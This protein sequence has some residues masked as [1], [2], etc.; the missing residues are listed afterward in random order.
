MKYREL[1]YSRTFNLGQYES[2]RIGLRVDL[3]EIED[4][5]ETF[6]T[7]KGRVFKLHEEGRLLEDS[8][9]A[10]EADKQSKK[11][12]SLE[13]KYTEENFN[14]LFF[15]TKQ[16]SKG[17]YQQTSKAATSN[18]AVF[19][20]LQAILKEHNGFCQL[21]AYKYWFDNQNPDVIDRRAK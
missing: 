12:V 2:E 21:G 10:V 5:D 20:G 7:M 1:E 9:A 11:T 14:K 4:I 17:P 3:D 8:K 6:K 16:G 19:Q 15:E 18:S 13:T